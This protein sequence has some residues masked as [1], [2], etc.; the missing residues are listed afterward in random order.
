MDAMQSGT[1][2][3]IVLFDM[4]PAMIR[5][6]LVKIGDALFDLCYLGS[7]RAECEQHGD[8]GTP[9]YKYINAFRKIGVEITGMSSVGPTVFALTQKADVYDRVLSYLK[10]MNIAESRIIETEVDNLGGTITEDGV[11]RSFTN[12]NWLKRLRPWTA[13]VKQKSAATPISRTPAWQPMRAPIFLVWWL[14][15]TSRPDH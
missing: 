15:L 3:Q 8:F 9:I 11:E 10:S 7:K 14:R 6:D 12:D 2:A 5:G 1:K 13:P 4:L